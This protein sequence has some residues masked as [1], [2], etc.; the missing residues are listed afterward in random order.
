ME[1]IQLMLEDLGRQIAEGVLKTSEWRARAIV[2]EHALS[3]IAAAGRQED[4]DAPTL[5]AV[6]D[7]PEETEEDQT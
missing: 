6:P 4:E 5:A 3:E 7:A 2:A 1:P